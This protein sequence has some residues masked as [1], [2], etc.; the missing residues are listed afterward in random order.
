M[1]MALLSQHPSC[2]LYKQE[3]LPDVEDIV[4]VVRIAAWVRV[5]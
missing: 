1:D 5:Q 2:S 4:G 3:Y